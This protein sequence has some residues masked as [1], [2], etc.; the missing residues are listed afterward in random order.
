MLLSIIARKTK[1]VSPIGSLRYVIKP[2][3][4]KKKNE[5]ICTSETRKRN[6]GELPTFYTL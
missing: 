6:A 5:K 2:I 1:L 4:I 3:I